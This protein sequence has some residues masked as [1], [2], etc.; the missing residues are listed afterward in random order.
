[1]TITQLRFITVLALAWIG[2]LCLITFDEAIANNVNDGEIVPEPATYR[3]ENYIAPT[4]KTLKGAVVVNAEEL[5]QLIQQHPDTAL[6]DVLPAMRKPPDFPDNRLWRPPPR[7]NI[8]DSIWLPNVGYGN[9]APNFQEYFVK[10]LK[11][12]KQK[13]PTRNLVFYCLENCWMSWNAAKKALELGYNNIY[14]FPGGTNEWEFMDYKLK[15]SKP[16]KMPNFIE[17]EK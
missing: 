12:L 4:P 5:H 3:T 6:I 16:I 15:T 17:L 7:L 8:P 14:W 10:N 11:E 1:M 2:I 9:P 13:N